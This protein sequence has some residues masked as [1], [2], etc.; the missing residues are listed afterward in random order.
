MGR[1]QLPWGCRGSEE[2][3]VGSCPAAAGLASLNVG[4]LM[5]AVPG[6]LSPAGARGKEPRLAGK[7][8]RED[9]LPRG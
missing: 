3:I 7:V 8:G 4:A 1:T 9:T 5:L 2:T 6:S